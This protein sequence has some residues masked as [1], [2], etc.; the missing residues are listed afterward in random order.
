MQGVEQPEDAAGT[1][2]IPSSD[3]E[4][5]DMYFDA[6]EA[7]GSRNDDDNVQDSNDH[8]G[9]FNVHDENVMHDIEQ[10]G[11]NINVTLPREPE[12]SGLRR[13]RRPRKPVKRLD[14]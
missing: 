4:D 8:V 14:L 11:E 7:N 1:S 2:E 3:N 5:N 13:S 10:E 6:P 12:N 9:D